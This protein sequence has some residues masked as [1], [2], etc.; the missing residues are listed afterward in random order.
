[1]KTFD[2]ELGGILRQERESRNITQQQMADAL[3]CTKMAVSYWESGKR[4]M[5]AETL[6]RYCAHL[7]VTTQYIFDRMDSDEE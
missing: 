5:Y 6:K 7:G 1:M 2:E 4:S 3:Q